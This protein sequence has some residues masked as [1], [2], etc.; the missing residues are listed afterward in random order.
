MK[1]ELQNIFT[2]I[3]YKTFKMNDFSLDFLYDSIFE[4][5]KD[6]SKVENILDYILNLGVLETVNND[7]VWFKHKTYK[8]YFAARYIMK[9]VKDKYNFIKEIIN[10]DAWSEVLIFIAGMF[11]DWQDQDIYLNLLLDYNLKLYIQCVKEKND[12]SKSLKNK[13]DNELCY[14][15]LNIMV[16]TYDKIVNK[17]FRQIKYLLNPFRYYSNYKDMELVIKGS[18]SE[19]RY[20]LYK[21]SLQYE[22]E[23]VIICDS[24]IVNKIDLVSTGGITSIIDINLSNLNLDSARYLALKSLKK[25]LLSIMDKRTLSSPELICERVEWL[26]R[27]IGIDDNNKVLDMVK[28][29]LIRHP[30]VRKYIYRNVDLIDLANAIIFLENENIKIEDYTLPKGDIDIDIDKNSYFIWQ[31]YSKERLVERIS[32]FFEL[33]KKSIMYI[34][35]NSFSGIKEL[36]PCYRNLPYQYTVKYYFNKNYLDGIV[37]N[38]YNDP[39]EL[40]Y[41]YEPCESNHEVPKLIECTQDDLRNDIHDMDDL[42]KKYSNKNY[43]VEGVSITNMGIS[44]LLHDE[45]LSKFVH[46]KMKKEIEFVFDGIDS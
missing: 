16:T 15:Y 5:C 10:D 26:K 37:D 14:M 25:E 19:R 34:L 45:Q 32:K 6:K 4:V 41:Y 43:M 29:E 36:L 12:L 40:S 9:I 22:G 8:E 3:A 42:V 17:Y 44:E 35:E 21:Y 1:I 2:H 33:Y 18:L 24:E 28:I 31:V 38:Y 30:N 13:S 46:N 7:V 20:L 23:N 11:E 27:K 39:G